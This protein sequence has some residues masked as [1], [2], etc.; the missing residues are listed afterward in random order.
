MRYLLA[1]SFSLLMIVSSNSG[2]DISG[3][4]NN[5]SEINKTLSPYFLVKSDNP[6]SENFPLLE[7]KADVKV[8]GVIAD[9]TVTQ[10]Y[11]NDGKK[12]IEA[13]YT[14]PASTR[15]AVYGLKMKIGERTIIA[16]IDKKEDAR[17]SYEEAKND[18]RTASLLEQFRPNVFQMNVAN[19][20]PGDKI[21]VELKYSEILVP[22][23]GIYEFIYPTVVGPRYTASNDKDNDGF[24]AAPYTNEGEKPSYR[25]TLNLGLETG[26]PVSEINS[27]SHK[28]DIIKQSDNASSIVLN[29]EEESGGNRDFILHYSLRGKK[30]ETGLIINET[31]NEN[32]FLLM[33]QAPKTIKRNIIPKREYIFIVDV[34]GSMNGFP[35]DIS[36]ALMKDLLKNLDQNEK[37]NILL[38]AGTSSL[39]SETSLS[40]NQTNI[41]K[42]IDFIAKQKGGGGTE[43]LPA[44]ER[45]FNLKKSAGF[46][47]SIII[48]TDGY[49]TVEKE[50]FDL[51]RNKLDNSNVFAFGIGSSVNRYIIEGIAKAGMGEP[52]V[53][54][55]KSTAFENAEEFRKYIQSP[56]M[57]DINVKFDG[58]MAYDIIPNKIPDVFADRPIIITGKYK[59]SAKGN[60][61]V[62][63]ITGNEELSVNIPVSLFNKMDESKSIR[64]FWARTKLAMLSDYSSISDEN[65]NKDAI[66]EIGLRYHLLTKFTSF[67]AV[68][69]EIRNQNSLITINQPLPL[70]SGVSKYAVG[71]SAAPLMARQMSISNSK[72]KIGTVRDKS[73]G[74]SDFASGPDYQSLE[75]K[76]PDPDSVIQYDNLP[77]A[78]PLKIQSNLEYPEFARMAGMEGKVFIKALISPWGT[79]EKSK[80]IRSE[81]ELLNKSAMKAISKTKFSAARQGKRNIYCWVTIPIDFKLDSGAKPELLKENIYLVKSGKNIESSQIIMIEVR[82]FTDDDYLLQDTYS[83]GKPIII[84]L[85]GNNE[86]FDMIKGLKKGSIIAIVE[87]SKNL[88]RD[89]Y[90]PEYLPTSGKI[91]SIIEIL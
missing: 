64:N 52:F 36:K 49:V 75:L 62:S 78:D 63:G 80:V 1:I 41:N 57:T 71:G 88:G 21:I 86:F 65:L 30:I 91:I 44:M 8:S 68:D 13:I 25:F 27:P 28:I 76:I 17:K 53:I 82:T 26:V 67:V 77:E 48:V 10:V 2:Q 83:S 32:F 33:L 16:K 6:E 58:F 35:L 14:F 15:A 23:N 87:D 9:V 74:E 37:F 3:N 38:F 66:T 22:T 34:S 4:Q 18:G 61:T 89:F 40:V 56:V 70:P 73:E 43:L 81:N 19:I 7:T 55:D 31:N 60:I 42:A 11:K 69:S 50:A 54:E 90:H 46:S 72:S 45:A 84:A 29:N 12:P 39:L 47:R 59:G 5:L 85:K 24:A 20:L 51:I 79:V